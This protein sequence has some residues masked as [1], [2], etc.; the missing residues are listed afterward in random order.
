MSIKLTDRLTTR[1]WVNSLA[2][3]TQS[4]IWAVLWLGYEMFFFV[5][6]SS[7]GSIVSQLIHF[8]FMCLWIGWIFFKLMGNHNYNETR[9]KINNRL[10]RHNFSRAI[11]KM[12][13]YG[14][15]FKVFEL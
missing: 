11:K 8:F 13:H 9:T 1:E 5:Y 12:N 14:L 7:K 3:F 10:I 6:F 4:Y 15:D 2:D